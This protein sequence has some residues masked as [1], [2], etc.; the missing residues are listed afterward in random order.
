[1]V[2]PRPSPSVKVRA[3]VWSDTGAVGQIYRFHIYA[4]T[5]MAGC[6]TE[7][8]KLRPLEKHLLGCGFTRLSERKPQRKSKREAGEQRR[9][10][11]GRG[12]SNLP[13][14]ATTKLKWN[15]VKSLHEPDKL[16]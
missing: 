10:R 13:P 12:G 16:R 15:Q 5:R 9:E 2:Q 8:M 3:A 11:R 4:P 14:F 7:G 1:M 6:G